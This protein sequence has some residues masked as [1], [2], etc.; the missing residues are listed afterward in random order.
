[1][2]EWNV[3]VVNVSTSQ[4]LYKNSVFVIRYFDN[5]F[6]TALY[7][8]IVDSLNI[9]RRKLQVHRVKSN[10]YHALSVTLYI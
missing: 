5:T 9:H 10:K 1:M 6:N 4:F 7:I 2:E 3:F 8:I